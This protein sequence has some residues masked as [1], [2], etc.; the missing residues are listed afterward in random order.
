MD[1]I[2][3]LATQNAL[4][5]RLAAMVQ[6]LD[7]VTGTEPS[8]YVGT[9]H[10]FRDIFRG[11]AQDALDNNT[12]ARFLRES[13]IQ[14]PLLDLLTSRVSI[15]P[16]PAGQLVHVN[17]FPKSNANIQASD[18]LVVFGY[19]LPTILGGTEKPEDVERVARKAPI[20][21]RRVF[22]AL[23]EEKQAQGITSTYTLLYSR[24]FTLAAVLIE[25]HPNPTSLYV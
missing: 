6:E 23:E 11:D 20:L 24:T 4:K 12:Y 25:N 9:L 3:T 22:A 7:A 18:L 8:R 14:R 1:P 2:S 16:A 13:G 19:F 15:S 5:Q 17:L 10:K 21:F